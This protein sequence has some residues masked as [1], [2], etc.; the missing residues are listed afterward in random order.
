M[1]KAR[2]VPDS[3]EQHNCLLPFTAVTDQVDLNP[4]SCVHVTCG[5]QDF[6]DYSVIVLFDCKRELGGHP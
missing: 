6:S 5:P 4:G 1:L 2:C 3:E